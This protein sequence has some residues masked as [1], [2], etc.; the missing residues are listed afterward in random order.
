MCDVNIPRRQYDDLEY[1][2]FYLAAAVYRLD[3]A[4]VVCNSL[5]SLIWGPQPVALSGRFMCLAEE[6]WH[7]CTAPAM[8]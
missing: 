1:C 4:G 2:P 3:A 7:A 8:Q 6:M 5:C